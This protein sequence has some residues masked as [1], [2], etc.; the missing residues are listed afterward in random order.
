MCADPWERF[1]SNS[2]IFRLLRRIRIEPV[3]ASDHLSDQLLLDRFVRNRDETAFAI[4]LGRHGPMVLSVGRRILHDVHRAEDVMQATFLSLIRHAGSIRKRASLGSWLHGV[5]WRLA[6]KSR[7]QAERAANRMRQHGAPPPNPS[8]EAIWG[9]MQ[10]I[11]D[12][13]LQRLPERYRLPLVLCYLEGQSRDE[14]AARLGWTS[15]RVKG[16]LERGREQLRMRLIRRA[17]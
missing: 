1:M 15:G 11:L 17:A 12:E 8:A 7:I 2:P 13:E 9:E 14:A 5:A 16:L 4:L 10:Q 3:L 6:H